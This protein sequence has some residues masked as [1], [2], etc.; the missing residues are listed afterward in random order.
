MASGIRDAFGLSWRISV[1]LHEVSGLSTQEKSYRHKLLLDSWARER[2]SGV[3]NSSRR[4]EANGSLL[5]G[6]SKLAAAAI[7][8][9]NGVLAWVPSL[10]ER[11]IQKRES[12][13]QGF[14][15]VEG[16]FFI[17][18]LAGLGDCDD[19]AGGGGGKTAQVYVKAAGKESLPM[20]S[21]RLFWRTR[22]SLT[23]L[24]L[25]QTSDHEVS[26]VRKA[27]EAADLRAPFLAGEILE[28]VG[29]EA[30]ALTFERPS[31]S[32]T[33][34]ITPAKAGDPS[35][36]PLLENYDPCVFRKRFQP[37]ALCALVRPDFII[38]SQAHTLAQLQQQLSIAAKVLLPG[39]VDSTSRN[40]SV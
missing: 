5:L 2:R 8:I 40:A 22:C 26:E 15:G 16:G 28:L 7:G 29:T 6:K 12:D 39:T 3:D 34:R 1:L 10:R 23:V 32:T 14:G 24:L 20:L 27:I 33:L 21:D 18:G 37:G 25:R 30:N 31:S 38:F 11:L 13:S 35:G 36:P 17:D 19:E 9:A 4:T